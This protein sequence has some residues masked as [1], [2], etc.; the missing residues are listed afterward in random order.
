MKTLIA[1]VG[2]LLAGALPAKAGPP[3][4]YE[5]VVRVTLP[6]VAT[7]SAIYAFQNTSTELDVVI[8]KIEISN[9]STM[10]IA[11]GL[12]A[13]WV[14]TSTSLTHSAAVTSAYSLTAALA[15][16]PSFVSVSTAPRNIQAEGDASILSVGGALSG[17][18]PIIRPLYVNN[19]EAATA[20]L[21]D[22]WSERE[23]SLGAAQPLVLPANSQRAIVIQQKRLGTAD[24]AAGSLLVKVFY[25]TR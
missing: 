2:L 11:G 9:V 25:T 15:S 21:V 12:A 14:Y 4:T 6:V 20:Q 23:D 7:S 10:T 24:I 17:V 18:P 16:Q 8:R 22:S 5:S 1:I 19:D 13:Y 3:A